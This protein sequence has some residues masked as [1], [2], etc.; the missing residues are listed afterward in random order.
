[1]FTKKHPTA[2]ER[3]YRPGFGYGNT[4]A[5]VYRAGTEEIRQHDF[6]ID[7]STIFDDQDRTIYIDWA[8]YGDLG[9]DIAA[10]RMYREIR[11]TLEALTH[12]PSQQAQ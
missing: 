3:S 1:M 7:L 12:A 9:H 5:D 8:H 6:A 11:P 4:L 10:T 2:L